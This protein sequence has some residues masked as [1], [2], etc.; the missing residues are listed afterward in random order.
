MKPFV[1][2]NLFDHFYGTVTFK[3]D[4]IVKSSNVIIVAVA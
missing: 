2:T 4:L 3:R 1:T